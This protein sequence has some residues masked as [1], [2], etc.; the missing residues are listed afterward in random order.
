M[1]RI[2]FVFGILAIGSLSFQQAS[3]TQPDPKK[4]HP[5]KTIYDTY[6]LAC[7]QEDGMGVPGMNPPLGKSEWVTG[8]KTRVIKV[9]LNGLDIP[10]EINGESYQ[11][12]MAP[13]DFLTNQQVADVLSYIRSNFGNQASAIT[14]EEV[15][16]IRLEKK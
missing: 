10:I 4:I 1:K 3:V 12:I 13:H 11:N 8:D 16:K 5:G 14:A 9:V 15:Q 6:C 7:H 2:V